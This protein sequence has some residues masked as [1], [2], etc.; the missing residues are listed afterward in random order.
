MRV[1]ATLLNSFS[2]CS[3][4]PV[5]KP[6]PLNIKYL[7]TTPLE[8]ASPFGKRFDLE[9]RSSFAVSAPLAHSTTALA[10]WKVSVFFSS[11]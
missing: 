3:K 10:R 1:T 8:L 5:A 9:T 7:P 2:S 4:T 11:K 6:P